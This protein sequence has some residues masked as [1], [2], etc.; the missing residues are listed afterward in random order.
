MAIPTEPFLWQIQII[1]IIVYW[2]T[3]SRNSNFLSDSTHYSRKNH[4][5]RFRYSIC[6]L[7]RNCEKV[8]NLLMLQIVFVLC[9]GKIR[10]CT[11]FWAPMSNRSNNIWIWTCNLTDFPILCIAFDHHRKIQNVCRTTKRKKHIWSR[12]H[13]LRSLASLFSSLNDDFSSKMFQKEYKQHVYSLSW[14]INT[15]TCFGLQLKFEEKNRKWKQIT[16]VVVQTV[17]GWG[18]TDFLSILRTLHVPLQGEG[19]WN[20]SAKKNEYLHL[21]DGLKTAS[22][23]VAAMTYLKHITFQCR[24]HLWRDCGITNRVHTTHTVV[25]NRPKRKGNKCTCFDVFFFRNNAL[26][27]SVYFAGR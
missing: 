7:A 19:T 22:A 11:L 8:L 25:V 6:L 27:L 14:L 24:T 23:T 5:D 1:K 12:D 21:C 10:M 4:H 18:R 3:G 2:A 13:H 20:G 17:C 16:I 15:V 26:K 9:Y